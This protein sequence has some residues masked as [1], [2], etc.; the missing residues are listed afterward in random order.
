[1]KSDLF[2][3]PLL[4]LAW[5]ALSARAHGATSLTIVVRNLPDSGLTANG[6][7]V[8]CVGTLN[9]WNNAATTATVAGGRLAFVFADL[10]TLSALDSS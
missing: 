6:Q 10:G 1:M 4:L 5:L 2:L 8:A 9:G 3:L 7:S